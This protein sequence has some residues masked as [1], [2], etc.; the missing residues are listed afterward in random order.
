MLIDYLREGIGKLIYLIPIAFIVFSIF[1]G[2]KFLT[3]RTIEFKPLSMLCE[4]VW[5]LV[6]ITILKI[7][8][9]IGGDF[10]T[11]SIINGRVNYSFA[12]FGEGLSMATL[13]NI[14]LFTPFGFFSSIVFKKLK[15]K[16]IY[17]IL[18]GLIFSGTIEFLQIFTGRFVQ[19]N[20]IL[21]NTLGTFLGYE[22]WV[23]LLKLNLKSKKRVK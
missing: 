8:G 23:I 11:T 1:T 14:A 6:V 17:G 18:I 5:I 13:L 21:M 19:L 22:I 9:I 7:T 20:D 4:F 2:G 3:K 15:N 10:N 12:L 16:W